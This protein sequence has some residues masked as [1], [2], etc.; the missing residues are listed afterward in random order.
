[1]GRQCS[2]PGWI[3]PGGPGWFEQAGGSTGGGVGTVVVGGGVVVVVGGGV[4]GVVV[5]GPGVG[6]GCFVVGDGLGGGVCAL[7]GFVVGGGVVVVVGGADERP[8]GGPPWP[9]GCQHHSHSHLGGVNVTVCVTVSAPSVAV[10]VIV[11]DRALRSYSRNRTCSDFPGAIG[12]DDVHVAPVRSAAR[13]SP[14]QPGSADQTVPGRATVT[15]IGFV[16]V[17]VLVAITSSTG[18]PSHNQF[19]HESHTSIVALSVSA[20]NGRTCTATSMATLMPPALTVPVIVPSVAAD[21]AVTRNSMITVSPGARSPGVVHVTVPVPPGH[22][23][24]VIEPDWASVGTKS[25]G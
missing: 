12:V 17:P 25:I 8:G 24:V 11:S 9:G 21:I 20:S 10:T 3:R 19:H 4:L 14:R 2:P 1:M 6:V 18:E 16:L 7:L 5:G 15:V 23:T 13:S 22:W